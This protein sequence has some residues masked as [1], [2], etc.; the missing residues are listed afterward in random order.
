[1]ILIFENVRSDFSFLHENIFMMLL[2]AALVGVWIN[3]NMVRMELG[4]TTQRD[5]ENAEIDI[6]LGTTGL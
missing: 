4:G 5:Q 2:C 6:I 1:M 3:T